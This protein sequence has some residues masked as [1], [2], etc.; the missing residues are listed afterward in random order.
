MCWPILPR[1]QL[2]SPIH[3]GRIFAHTIVRER[4]PAN[5]LL[6]RFSHHDAAVASEQAERFTKNHEKKEVVRPR[7]RLLRQLRHEL[8][9]D[10]AYY[11]PSQFPHQNEQPIAHREPYIALSEQPDFTTVRQHRRPIIRRVGAFERAEDGSAPLPSKNTPLGE[12]SFG[13]MRKTSRFVTV[14]NI[15]P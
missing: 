14:S 6:L 13:T 15:N 4:R 3:P 10:S 2:N 11:D 5:L 9:L 12:P 8:Q 1:L 7:G